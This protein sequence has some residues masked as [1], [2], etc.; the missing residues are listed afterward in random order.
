[1]KK[2]VKGILKAMSAHWR[3]EDRE[4]VIATLSERAGDM[5]RWVFFPA[6]HTTSMHAFKYSQGSE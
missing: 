3:E 1:M 5:F 4:L 2:A 6:G